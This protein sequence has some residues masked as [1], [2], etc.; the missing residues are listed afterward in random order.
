MH[1]ISLNLTDLL[2]ALFRG[3]LPCD[4]TDSKE[5]WLWAVLVDGVWKEHGRQVAACTPYLPGSFD[6]PPR[7]PAEKINSGYK[8]WEF[9]MYIFG[10][11]PCLL[12]ATPLPEV[13]FRNFCKL[14]CAVRLTLARRI[15]APNLR[16][17]QRLFVEFV[18]EFE[19]L[20]YQRRTDRLHFIR[21]SIHALPHIPQ[22]CERVG[23][24]SC[25]TQWT[26]ECT[27][28]NLGQE[29]K[30]HSD[31]YTNLSQ[32]GVRRAQVNAL[33]AMIPDLEPDVRPLPRGAEEVGG[34]YVLLRAA[35]ESPS[36]VSSAEGSVLRAYLEQAG[37]AL[38]PDWV[39]KV[40]RWARLRLPNG[41][42]ARSLWKE[43]LKSLSHIRI[44]RNVK[45]SQ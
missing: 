39:P 15:P 11:G 27:I 28:G 31:P 8:A 41:Q 9:L 29:I 40:A 4:K 22:E 38:R 24:Q 19:V 23:P 17:A 42:V 18:E 43:S 32:R 25:Y 21:Q 6:R 7:N 34:G 30:L 2:L 1:L 26:M 13:Y 14:V 33:K 45:V 16:Y 5:T 10:L 20:Y 36:V 12:Y 44:A 35:E 3:T 37:L